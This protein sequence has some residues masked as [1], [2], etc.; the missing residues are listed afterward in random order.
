MYRD[1]FKAIYGINLANSKPQMFSN[2]D[3]DVSPKRVVN[4]SPT[5]DME[6]TQYIENSARNEAH[7]EETGQP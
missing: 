1:H 3:E 7:H 4:R 6:Q 5:P 2:S